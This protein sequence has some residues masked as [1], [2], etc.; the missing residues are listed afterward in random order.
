ML[1]GEVG[2]GVGL[3]RGDSP[4]GDERLYRELPTQELSE[5]AAE[6]RP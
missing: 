4:L 3:I 5:G 6:E 2:E 1:S